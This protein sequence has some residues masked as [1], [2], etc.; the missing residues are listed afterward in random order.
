MNDSASAKEDSAWQRLDRQTLVQEK[1]LTVYRDL[2]RLPNGSQKQYFLTKKSDIVVI[3]ALTDQNEVIMLKEYKYAA[4]KYLN[5]L[6]AGHIENNESPIEAAKRELL[7]ETGFTA[8]TYEYI[9]TLFESPVQDLHKIEVVFV[10]NAQRVQAANL[11]ASEDLF[12]YT[13]TIPDLKTKV[14]QGEVQS[15]STLGA[16]AR[17]GV[18]L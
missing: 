4:N 3:V 15:C 7:E 1:F 6:P 16:L 12:A 2:V 14:L 13:L 9:G 18:L 17:T 11:E 10:K 5:V 8:M